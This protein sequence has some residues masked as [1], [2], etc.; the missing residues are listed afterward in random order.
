M[1]EVLESAST[2]SWQYIKDNPKWRSYPAHEWSKRTGIEIIYDEVSTSKLKDLWKNWNNMPQQMKD[3]SDEKSIELYGLNNKAHFEKLIS[4]LN[5]SRFDGYDFIL[6][7]HNPRNG[8]QHYD[9]RFMDLKSNKLLHS[10]ACPDNF[11]D[12][13]MD[14]KKMAIY[15]TRDHDPRWLTLKSYRLENID[16]GTINYKIYKPKNFFSLEFNGD[17]L[18][19]LFYLFKLNS[20]T[21]RDDI[22]LMYKKA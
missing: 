21:K 2:P 7:R 1:E 17:I 14:G 18:K 9:L 4:N 13:I 10:F 20:S 11:L 16:K 5:H 15:K 22:W 8:T 19:G 12:N 6:H 3:L